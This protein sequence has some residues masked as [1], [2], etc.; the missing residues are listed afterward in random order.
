MPA[1]TQFVVTIAC[2]G[3]I[4]FTG[5]GPVSS[6]QFVFDAQGN[7][8][9]PDTVT[10]NDAGT[11]TVTETQTGGAASVT[12]ECEGTC[13][14][15]ALPS[16]GGRFGPRAAGP[17]LPEVCETSGLQGDPITVNIESPRQ[18]ATVTVTDTFEAAPAPAPP[19]AP[20][21]EAGPRF[22]G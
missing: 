3:P 5:N 13:E 20:P 17:P 12:Y 19:A 11:C 7:P 18:Q 4:I 2:D 15:T 9:G 1:G 21:V 10:F 22:T 14:G 6:A 16:V 8:V